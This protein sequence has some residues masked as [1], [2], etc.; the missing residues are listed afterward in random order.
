MGTPRLEFPVLV[1]HDTF[2][3]WAVEKR[4]ILHRGNV[5]SVELMGLSEEAGS[6]AS[7]DGNGHFD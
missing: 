5:R 3:L 7:G 2:I 6:D 4:I 1:Q